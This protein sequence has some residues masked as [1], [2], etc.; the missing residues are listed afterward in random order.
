VDYVEYKL[1]AP[2]VEG[3]KQTKLSVILPGGVLSD[4]L[5]YYSEGV[6]VGK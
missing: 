3:I 4:S 6:G 5:Y 1:V 2:I